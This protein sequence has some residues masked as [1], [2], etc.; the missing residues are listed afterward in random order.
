MSEHTG[1]YRQSN[2]RGGRGR[3]GR[4]YGGAGRGGG[5]HNKKSN[6]SK[7]QKL[8]QVNGSGQGY[9]AFSVTKEALIFK[10]QSKYGEQIAETIRT[11]TKYDFDAN[12]PRLE[13]SKSTDA[14]AKKTE[15]EENKM[16]YQ[17]ELK[18]H[19]AEKRKYNDDLVKVYG[20]IMKDWCT[21]CLLYTSPS[22]RDS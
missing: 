3:G 22:P 18:L 17:E 13:V 5:S 7:L 2:S 14:D 12:K 6:N 4:G 11:K 20:E 8:F 15:D 16:T 21:D 10:L 9:A 19:L 1:R